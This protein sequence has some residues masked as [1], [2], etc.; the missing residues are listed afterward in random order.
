MMRPRSVLRW[1]RLGSGIAQ[2]PSAFTNLKYS[3]VMRLKLVQTVREIRS[4]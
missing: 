4:A 3:L 2:S 1:H